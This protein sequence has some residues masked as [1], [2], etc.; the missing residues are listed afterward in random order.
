MVCGSRLIPDIVKE[1]THNQRKSSNNTISLQIGEESGG[2]RQPSELDDPSLE[3][4][5]KHSY[6]SEAPAELFFNRRR[7]RC[8][9]SL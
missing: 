5:T 6:F 2:F 7:E 3:L 8:C 9:S 1:G 4:G